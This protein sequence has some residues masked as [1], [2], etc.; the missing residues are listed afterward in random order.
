MTLTPKDDLLFSLISS[1]SGHC[2]QAGH[3]CSCTFCKQWTL[4]SVSVELHSSLESV[5]VCVL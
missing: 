5:L 4:S 2:H 3:V 1:N